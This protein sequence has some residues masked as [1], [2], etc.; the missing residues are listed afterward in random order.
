LE[1]AMNLKSIAIVTEDLGA[2]LDEGFKK[3][4][5]EIACA[6]TGKLRSAV[7]TARSG[8][9]PYD[10]RG[11]PDNRLLF[12]MP[13]SKELRRFGCDAVLYIPQS[14]ATLSSMARAKLISVQ[15]GWKPVALLS[16]QR[17]VYSGLD[18]MVV[19][20]LKPRLALVLSDESLTVMAE[21]GVRA[22][23][24]P[25]G[26][27]TTRFR[28]AEG[29]EKKRLREKYGMGGGKM[30]LHI[31]HVSPRRNLELLKKLRLGGARLA[32]VT[33]TS[34]V[35]H[36]GVKDWLERESVMVIDRYIENIE[37][38]Y[39]LADCYVFPTFDDTGA[40]EM[41]LSVLEAMAT[42]IPVVTTAFG[43]IPGRFMEQGG[44]FLCGTE[45]EFVGK[46][47]QAMG[48]EGAATR[49]MVYE[50][51]WQRSADEIIRAVEQEVA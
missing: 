42:N 20:L 48:L 1:V 14:S 39:R 40:I 47:S 10:V 11:L 5:S 23:R 44:L 27:D 33:S 32:V 31:G 25:L 15:A 38:M 4:A 43:A 18:R 17:R 21:A 16:L 37:E 45:E 6:I 3:A 46:F 9:L 41:P 8:D 26:V 50:F 30:A 12:G 49:E 7:F 29:D 35:P 2:P 13:F 24:V 19:P 34:T 51:T 22:R 36:A 28:P